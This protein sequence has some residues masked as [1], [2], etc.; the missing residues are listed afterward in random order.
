ME[1]T[2]TNDLKDKNIGMTELVKEA[3]RSGVTF[4]EYDSYQKSFEKQIR[5]EHSR[6][7]QNQENNER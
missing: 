7:E 5:Q 4:E 3:L 6:N 2:D 1:S